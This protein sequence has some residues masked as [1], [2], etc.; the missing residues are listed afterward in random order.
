MGR[1]DIG[2]LV[3]GWVVRDCQAMVRILD[4][5]L[6]SFRDLWVQK[7]YSVRHLGNVLEDNEI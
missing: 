5:D 7:G 6:Q 1:D 2:E 3:R 4:V